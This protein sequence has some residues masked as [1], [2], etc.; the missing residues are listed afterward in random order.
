M[1][2]LGHLLD[3]DYAPN[4]RELFDNHDPGKA[5]VKIL[6]PKDYRCLWIHDL[7]PLS[8]S[9][10]DKQPC[11]HSSEEKVWFSTKG[12]VCVMFV[13]PWIKELSNPSKRV[14]AHLPQTYVLSPGRKIPSRTLYLTQSQ[15]YDLMS[16]LVAEKILP[17]SLFTAYKKQIES[18]EK[19]AD[20][21]HKAQRMMEAYDALSETIPK[22]MQA[23]LLKLGISKEDI[24]AQHKAIAI[25]LINEKLGNC[26]VTKDTEVTTGS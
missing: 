23:K 24:D 22:G 10:K 1:P 8:T 4:M 7:P 20:A 26:K 18:D 6:N 14:L 2:H 13:Y 11:T 3:A 16:I 9:L 25:R 17:R 15:R 19:A 5:K 12:S 21:Q